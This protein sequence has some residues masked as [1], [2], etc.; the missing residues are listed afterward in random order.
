[1]VSAAAKLRQTIRTRR[2]YIAARVTCHCADETG[3]IYF[4]PLHICRIVLLLLLQRRGAAGLGELQ[5]ANG[6]A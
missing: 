4:D 5:G 2:R 6:Q 3:N 1:M